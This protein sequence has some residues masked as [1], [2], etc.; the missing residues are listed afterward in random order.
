MG[1]YTIEARADNRVASRKNV[2]V[3]GT[4]SVELTLPTGNWFD[5]DRFQISRTYESMDAEDGSHFT[6]GLCATE[7]SEAHTVVAQIPD[8]YLSLIHI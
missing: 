2:A 6:D 7:R 4:A 3:P 8:A 1:T 5:E